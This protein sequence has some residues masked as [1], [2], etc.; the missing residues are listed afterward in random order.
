MF[1][2]PITRNLGP[3]SLGNLTARNKNIGNNG[4]VSAR[5]I[6]DNSI[7]PKNKEMKLRSQI[8][9]NKN[10]TINSQNYES[11]I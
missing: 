2:K 4:T 9:S 6:G 11:E 5:R 3:I 8:S 1:D 7:P 10:L